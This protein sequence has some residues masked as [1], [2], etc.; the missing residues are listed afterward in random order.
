MLHKIDLTAEPI[1]VLGSM[2]LFHMQTGTVII[3]VG[4]TAESVANIKDELF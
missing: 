1:P 2:L 4:F 3:V